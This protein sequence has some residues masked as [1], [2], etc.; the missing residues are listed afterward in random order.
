MD[1]DRR[2]KKIAEY[3]ERDDRTIADNQ[4]DPAFQSATDFSNRL[5]LTRVCAHHLA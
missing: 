1:C 5:M 3:D 2:N 4:R